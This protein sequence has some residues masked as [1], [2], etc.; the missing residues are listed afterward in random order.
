[1][2]YTLEDFKED[3]EACDDW[4]EGPANLFQ[5]YFWEDYKIVTIWFKPDGSVFGSSFP[6]GAF[7]EES[8]LWPTF[9]LIEARVVLAGKGK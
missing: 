3:F 2:K 7:A 8:P 9:S 5:L 6:S 4:W 1:M